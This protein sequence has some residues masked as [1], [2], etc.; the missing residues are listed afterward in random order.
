M[1]KK[2]V[3]TQEESK[4]IYLGTTIKE[5]GLSN[6]SIFNSF[7]NNIKSAIEKYPKIKNL[8]FKINADLGKIKANILKTGTKENILYNSLKRELGGK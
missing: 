2:I 3:K 5:F 4:V 7:T 8:M 1:S 6:G